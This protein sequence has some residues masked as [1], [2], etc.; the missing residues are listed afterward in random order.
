MPGPCASVGVQLNTPVVASIVA[1][2]ASAAASKVNVD[3][4]PASTSVAVAVKLSAASSFTIWLPM[5]PSTG[6]SFTAAIV[7]AT[8]AVAV[9]PRPSLSV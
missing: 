9:P 3:A 2:K 8:V 7:S 6:T 5:V 1:P 4:C